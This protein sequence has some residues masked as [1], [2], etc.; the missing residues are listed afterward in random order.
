MLIRFQLN[1]E[2][3]PQAFE[4]LSCFT[5]PIQLLVVSLTIPLIRATFLGLTIPPVS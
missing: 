5:A 2:L 1:F 3:E 4:L